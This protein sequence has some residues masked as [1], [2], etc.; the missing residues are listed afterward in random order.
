MAGLND[1]VVFNQYAKS[2][3]TEVIDQQVRLWNEATAGAL[4]LRSG[5]NDGDFAEE[6]SYELLTDLYGN[7]NAYG[8]GALAAIDLKQLL[9]VS[10]KVG[11][12][13]KPVQYTGTSFDWTLRDP[14]EAGAVFGTQLGEA[15]MQYM[16]NTAIGAVS[17]AMSTAGASLTYDGTASVATLDSLNNGSR[18]F[19]DRA[20]AI[21]AWIMHS[22]SLHDIYGQ[23]LQNSN[24]L[25]EFGTVQVMS[26]GFGRRLIMTDSPDLFF[27]NAG[28]DNYYQLGLVAGAAVVED[29]GDSR[30]YEETKIE[31][32]N[33]KQMIK[34][35]S[36]FNVG[37]KGY[38]WDK[39][40]GGKSPNDAALRL[41]TNWDQYATSLKDTAGV[42]VQTL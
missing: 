30:I 5:P 1:F 20:S 14:R 16:L 19:G 15:K 25:F 40:N 34:E 8:T 28:T 22:K 17:S 35:E 3:A 26:D 37:L 18:L 6:A 27:D 29:N 21:A 33:A 9:D 13:S 38:A 12:G 7:R 31:L 36:S 11:S 10:V 4:V 42:R 39:A 24:R 2:A 41:N 23:A 32:E